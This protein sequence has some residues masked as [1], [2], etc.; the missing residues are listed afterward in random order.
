MLK[1]KIKVI[2][3]GILIAS[4][5]AV[6]FFTEARG[7]VPC[8]GY[9]ANGTREAP[10]TVV[11]VFIILGTVTN[12]LIM[13]AGLYATFQII[14]AGWWLAASMGDEESITKRKNM[15]TSAIMGLIMV[16]FAFAFVNSTVNILLLQGFKK[17]TI[18][19]TN[20]LS[21]MKIDPQACNPNNPPK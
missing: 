10:C 12:W 4:F 11:D 14:A 19:L 9:N 18:D 2:I 16:L 21:Y 3:L 13:A 7:L 6:P 15:L 5:I 20:P 1:P 8:G 17:C